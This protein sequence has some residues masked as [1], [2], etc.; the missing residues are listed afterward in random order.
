MN[1]VFVAL[2]PTA[3]ALLVHFGSTDH[4]LKRW[5]VGVLDG[6]YLVYLLVMVVAVLQLL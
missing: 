2:M 6:I 1:L 4:G 3:L 5:Q